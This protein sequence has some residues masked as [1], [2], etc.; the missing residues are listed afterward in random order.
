MA[1]SDP[2]ASRI[3]FRAWAEQWYCEH[4]PT[5]EVT[6]AVTNDFSE[7]I[8]IRLDLVLGT[9]LSRSDS[10]SGYSGR[11]F[12]FDKYDFE[13]DNDRD[14]RLSQKQQ[15]ISNYLEQY[16]KT[17][18]RIA[19][20]QNRL[21]NPKYRD[22]DVKIELDKAEYRIGKL[23]TK[24]HKLGDPYLIFD[25]P[26]QCECPY[27]TGRYFDTLLPEEVSLFEILLA[28]IDPPGR[29][30]GVRGSS[31]LCKLKRD[32]WEALNEDIRRTI[33]DL[34]AKLITSERK[35][36]YFYTLLGYKKS[37]GWF[38]EV[39][40]DT[41][42]EEIRLRLLAP[43]T[44]RFRKAV[45][46]LCDT[47]ELLSAV[48]DLDQRQDA[49]TNLSHKLNQLN[50]EMEQYRKNLPNSQE[51]DGCD[52]HCKIDFDEIIAQA[53]AQKNDKPSDA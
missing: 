10:A 40:G 46:T 38:D 32:E 50:G 20:L 27:G 29:E 53:I 21:G 8:I 42:L 4:D 1:T 34:I 25:D 35:P 26:L 36:N 12:F 24:L 19:T 23:L 47:Y 7:K 18:D 39:Y 31:V 16:Q 30:K 22:E 9:E 17:I 44:Y 15:T 2:K 33:Y 11:E 45:L 5:V 51:Q 48:E 43:E 6:A 28:S 41:K 37:G 13:N 3:T 14:L 52:D 49:L